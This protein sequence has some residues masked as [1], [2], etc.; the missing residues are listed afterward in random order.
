[1][2]NGIGVIGQHFSLTVR[3]FLRYGLV[4]TALWAA[5][6]L[7]SQLLLRLAV[8]LG[9]ISRL[10]GLIAIAPVI[11]LQLVIFVA[12]FVILRNGL[13]RMRLRRKQAA[14]QEAE[15]VEATPEPDEPRAPLTLA[16]TAVLIPFYGYYAGWGLLGDTLRTYSQLFYSAQMARI[17]FTNPQPS[18]AALDIGA[19]AWVAVAVGMIWLLRRF[20]LSR[21]KGEG[22]QYWSMLVV[23]C[24]AT[25]ALLGLYVLSGWQSQFT[26][27]L[28]TLPS[29]SEVFDLISPA[30]AAGISDTSRVPVDWPLP[31]EPWPVLVALFWYALLPLVWFNLGAITYGHNISAVRDETQRYAGGMIRRW[32]AMPKPVTDFLA[33]F[34]IGMVKRWHAVTNGILLAASAGVA[35]TASV[36]VLWRLVDWLGNWAWIGLAQLIGPQDILTWQVLSVPL[37]ALFNAPGAPPGGLLVSPLQFCILAAGLEL[38]GRAQDMARAPVSPAAAAAPA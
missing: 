34:W 8:E 20:A 26:D 18:A 15:I 23:A 11:L 28:A 6:A 13:P 2:Q 32:Q 37:N 29:P 14:A 4:L 33:H 17:D 36:L 7:L 5:G 12:F 22:S 31:R 27:W 25:W 38:A 16:L 3:L 10:L 19:T 24:E 30:E 1:M 21:S 35:L 9:M